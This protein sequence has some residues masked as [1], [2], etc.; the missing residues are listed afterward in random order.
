MA[1]VLPLMLLVLT[2]IASFSMALYQKLLLTEA[3]S[4]AGR[5]LA[6]EQGQTDPCSDTWT[7]LTRSA[8]GLTTSKLTMTITWTAEPSGTTKSYP[9]NTCTPMGTGL[10]SGDYGQV[11]AS[12][13][14]VLQ[15]VNIWGQGPGFQ[16]CT[17]GAAVAEDIQ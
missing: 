15:V 16:G 2:G 5:V 14:C 11:S 12:Y 1:L 3:V 4:S 10:K 13:P 17:V 6:A 9:N 8:P 7:A